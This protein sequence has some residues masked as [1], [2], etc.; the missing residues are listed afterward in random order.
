MDIEGAEARLLQGARTTLA[1]LRPVLMLELEDRHLARF[2]ATVAE[3]VDALGADGYAART[4]DRARGWVPRR[5]DDGRRNVLFVPRRT[6][7]TGQVVTRPG[8]SGVRTAP[9]RP[10][11]PRGSHR[12]R[13]GRR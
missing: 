2:G 13:R 5:P 7:T 10:E 8:R 1:T 3:I 6:L 4:W 9:D 11:H 12:D